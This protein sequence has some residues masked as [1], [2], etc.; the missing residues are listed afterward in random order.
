MPMEI[1]SDLNCHSYVLLFLDDSGRVSHMDTVV[2]ALL[3][4]G[5]KNL[6]SVRS[7]M[8]MFKNPSSIF[9]FLGYG[10]VVGHWTGPHIVASRPIGHSFHTDAKDYRTPS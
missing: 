8:R 10:E 9:P 5:L 7:R 2:P 1:D 4:I 3:L 6:A